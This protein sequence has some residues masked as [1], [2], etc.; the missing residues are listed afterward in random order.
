V[1]Q[2]PTKDEHKKKNLTQGIK[3]SNNEGRAKQECSLNQK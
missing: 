2:E 3:H 1:K